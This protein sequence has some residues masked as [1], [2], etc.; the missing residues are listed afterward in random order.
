MIYLSKFVIPDEN[1]EIEFFSEQKRT[2]YN[3]YYPFG[4]FPKLELKHIKFESVT[5]LYG[6]NGTGKST[7]LNIIAEKLKIIRNSVFNKS[8]FYNDYIKLCKADINEKIPKS[9]RIIT[10]DDVFNYIIDIRNLN[11]GID[12]KREE[13]FKEYTENKYADFQFKTMNDLEKLKAVNKSRSKSQS[14][15][16]KSELINNVREYSNGESAFKFFTEKISEKA[17]YLLDEPEN[18]LSPE[19]QIS[20]AQYIENAA[21]FFGCQFVI[22]THSPFFL[23]MKN[24]QIYNLDITPVTISKWTEL[25]N[26]KTYFEFFENHRKE[27]I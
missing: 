2:C 4:I 26:V 3:T 9:S 6:D 14:Q 23:S 12:I 24:A 27:F 22:S 7:L 13:L 15:Y 16:V 19:R 10:S 17:L 11:N 21:R 8:N 20:L 18:S 25:K 1:D 5:I